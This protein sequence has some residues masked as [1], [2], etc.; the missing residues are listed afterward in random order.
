[1]LKRRHINDAAQTMNVNVVRKELICL[2]PADNTKIIKI[3]TH[4]PFYLK[5]YE[6]IKQFIRA[7]IISYRIVTQKT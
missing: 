5:R 4:G 2:L 1:M 3:N 6:E 7:C